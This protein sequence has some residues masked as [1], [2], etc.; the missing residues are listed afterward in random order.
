MIDVGLRPLLDSVGKR[1]VS[2]DGHTGVTGGPGGR[3][4]TGGTRE[5]EG[6]RMRIPW[7]GR[8]P[9]TRSGRG[10]PPGGRRKLRL[11]IM[12]RL[13]ISMGLQ[14]KLAGTTGGGVV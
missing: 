8:G 10:S 6:S 4:G 3:T 14:L 13:G 9:S 7:S 12:P 1:L 11:L 2:R 5:R